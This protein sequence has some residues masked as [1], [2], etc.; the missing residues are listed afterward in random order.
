MLK[1]KRRMLKIAKGAF[2]IAATIGTAIIV[3]GIVDAVSPTY[4]RKDRFM[5]LVT[6][7]KTAVLVGSY[8]IGDMITEKVSEATDRV[9]DKTVESIREV[10]ATFSR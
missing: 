4:V 5:A 1:N 8:V 6:A 9:W 10:K 3:K 7:Q 2:R